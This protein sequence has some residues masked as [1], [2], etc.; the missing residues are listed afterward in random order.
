MLV[1]VRRF[2]A[3]RR[4]PQFNRT[5]LEQALSAARIGYCWAGEALG[6]RRAPTA[7]PSRHPAWRDPAFRAYADYMDSEEFRG[8][9]SR[10]LSRTTEER[11]VIMCA[12]TLWWKCHRRLLSDAASLRGTRVVHLITADHSEEHPPQ[13]AMRADERGWPVYDLGVQPGLLA[14]PEARVDT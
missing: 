2:P 8:A 6:G 14:L 9:F 1:D 5:A 10:L 11:I 13:P 4:N 12:E 7:G 3:S